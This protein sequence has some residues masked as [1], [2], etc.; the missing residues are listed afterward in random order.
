MIQANGKGDSGEFER[1]ER[2]GEGGMET[3]RESVCK[4]SER[5]TRLGEGE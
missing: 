2:E 1:G 5:V 3:S 4:I